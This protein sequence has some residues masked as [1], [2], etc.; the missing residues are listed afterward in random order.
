MPSS[1]KLSSKSSMSPSSP[2]SVPGLEEVVVQSPRGAS[3]A[4]IVESVTGPAA[5]NTANILRLPVEGPMGSYTNSEARKRRLEMW[6]SHKPVRVNI[7]PRAKWSSSSEGRR[8]RGT[9]K[10]PKAIMRDRPPTPRAIVVYPRLRRPPVVPAHERDWGRILHFTNRSRS[11]P[12]YR[13]RSNYSSSSRRSSSPERSSSPV[14]SSGSRSASPRRSSGSRSASPRRSPSFKRSSDSTWSP[15]PRRLS[16]SRSPR[17]VMVRINPPRIGHVFMD[18]VPIIAPPPK[19][20]LEVEQHLFRDKDNEKR[21][22]K[23]WRKTKKTLS[24]DVP[25]S[26]SPSSSSSSRHS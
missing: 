23:S 22:H 16:W 17:R 11:R 7:S 25:T 18:K 6:S 26:S 12:R 13:S 5:P 24:L 1:K 9:R 15:T 8:K 2:V 21:Q 4:V 20:T 3:E 19:N 10:F 14:R